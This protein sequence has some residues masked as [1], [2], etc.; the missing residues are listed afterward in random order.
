MFSTSGNL[1]N[2]GTAT[3]IL[4]KIDFKIKLVA[5]DKKSHYIIIKRSIHQ[6]DTTIVNT[7]ISNIRA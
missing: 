5:R 1:R 2:A 4:D 7:Y 6:E 3:L